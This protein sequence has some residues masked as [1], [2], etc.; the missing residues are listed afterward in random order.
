MTDTPLAHLAHPGRQIT[1]RVTPRSAHNRITHENN[2]IRI[3]VTEAPD[4]GKANAAALRLLSKALGVAKS[5]LTLIRGHTAR[6]K[7]FAID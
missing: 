3:H 5:R 6:D 4:K 2:V 1:V 7:T